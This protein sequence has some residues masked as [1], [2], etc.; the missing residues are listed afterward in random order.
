MR[1]FLA[2]ALCSVSVTTAFAAEP[3]MVSKISGKN[4]TW[5]HGDKAV[6]PRVQTL[7]VPGDRVSAGK[8][9][10]VEVEYLADNCTVRIDAGSSVV[11]SETS[12]C[13]APADKSAAA[14]A[15]EAKVVAATAPVVEVSGK[16]GPITRVNKGE[17]MADATVGDSLKLGDEV[18]A[19]VDSSV[20]LTFAQAQCSYTVAASS[21]YKIAEQA[22]C[23]STVGQLQ[24]GSVVV[25]TAVQSGNSS[26]T[27]MTGTATGTASTAGTAGA[28]LLAAG[29]GTAVA[30]G[31]GAV[32]VAGAVAVIA[33]SDDNNN[34]NNNP[35]TPD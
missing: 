15:E 20:T 24:G 33:T 4:V 30:L 18:F 7:L 10:F 3:A 5:Q 19:G 14:P 16:S 13:A 11:I 23:V 26:G 8:G 25:P 31:V 29:T 6:T 21:V 27:V 34:N 28:G 2:A 17:G 35:A 1:L 32:A 9:S 12:P 22:P